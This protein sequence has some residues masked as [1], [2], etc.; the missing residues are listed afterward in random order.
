MVPIT[1]RLFFAFH[2]VTLIDGNIAGKDSCFARLAFRCDEDRDVEE[3]R[4]SEVAHLTEVVCD[5]VDLFCSGKG[6]PISL[7]IKIHAE[8]V[9]ERTRLLYHPQE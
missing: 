5:P 9:P 3:S 7:A 1:L 6:A 2:G 4:W 8:L